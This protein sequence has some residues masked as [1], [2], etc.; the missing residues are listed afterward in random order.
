MES[1]WG[2][3]AF[4]VGDCFQVAVRIV[5]IDRRFVWVRRACL[6]YVYQLLGI[7]VV[8]VDNLAG[9]IC[10]ARQLPSPVVGLRCERCIVI[11]GLL[12]APTRVVMVLSGMLVSVGH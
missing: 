12:Q 7:V 2:P 10:Y 9:L 4:R 1:R 8:V 5:G 3:V 11:D 6:H